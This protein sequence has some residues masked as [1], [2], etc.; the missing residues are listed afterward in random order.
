MKSG[1]KSLAMVGTCALSVVIHLNN[2]II[3]NCG[4]SQSL[5]ITEDD[6]GL[7]FIKGN[8]QLSVNNVS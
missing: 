2:I 4:D 6:K 7:C 1:N 5:I 3:A 8:E